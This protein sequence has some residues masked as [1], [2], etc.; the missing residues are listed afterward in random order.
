MSITAGAEAHLIE[1]TDEYAVYEYGSYEL[2]IPQR[3]RICCDGRLTVNL[4]CFQEYPALSI[5]EMIS[6]GLLTVRN[7]SNC[8]NTTPQFGLD[9]I[10]VPLL[11][12]LFKTVQDEQ[13]VPDKRILEL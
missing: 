11:T 3:A 5:G 2:K 9:T 4:K 1:L 10:A 12:K 7:C 8:R 13:G 6:R